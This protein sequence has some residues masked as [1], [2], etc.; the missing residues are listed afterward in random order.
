MTLAERR[1]ARLLAGAGSGVDAGLLEHEDVRRAVRA[2]RIPPAPWR[3][4]QRRAMGR[5]W[6][7]YEQD[8][9]PALRR[10]R[11]A[12]FGQAADDAPARVLVRVDEFPHA[13]ALDEP[14]SY[15][16]R[17]FERFHSI[18]S[19]AG[20]PYL[21]ALT[22]MLS[23]DYLDPARRDGRPI[24]DAELELAAR[25]LGEGAVPA[26][27]G[28]DHRTRHAAPRRHSEFAGLTPEEAR[29]RVGRADG[30]LTEAGIGTRVFVPPFNRFDA[31][32]YELLADRF[33]IVCGG[34]ETVAVL[35]YHRTPL[36]RGEAVYMPS[37]PPFYGPSAEVEEAV[38][39]HAQAAAGLW[40]PITLH[41]GWEADEGWA[42]L[43]RMARAIAP[44]AA[45]WDD[46][47]AEVDASR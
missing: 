19:N 47:L 39:Q 34:L 33:D 31:R 6:L 40:V 21:L 4:V 27:H 10:A 24:S 14:E 12:L 46:F 29:E 8:C 11:R 17:A 38:R 37:Y 30:I 15:G 36:W 35:G 32:H 42:S 5:G 28:L 43:E 44:Y 23:H 13:R 20:V 18:L 22:P 2:R 9:L 1:S 45:S 7:G 41:W 26:L 3:A 16:S 25:V